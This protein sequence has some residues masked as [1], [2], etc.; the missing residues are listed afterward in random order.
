M[1]ARA[2]HGFVNGG[3]TPVVL[4]NVCYRILARQ[5]R[6]FTHYYFYLSRRNVG[7]DGWCVGPLLSLPD[8]LLPER[9][10]LHRKRTA[11]RVRQLPQKRPTL[12]WPLP[13]PKL[14]RPPPNRF[15]A[16]VIRPRLDYWTLLLGPKFSRRER[17]AMKLRRFYAI[18]EIEYCC[19]FVFQRHF[20]IHRIFERGC[21]IGLCRLPRFYR[22]VSCSG[23][24]GEA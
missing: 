24:C 16:E 20:L 13:T 2:T 10:Q 6:R 18:S 12:F 4:G 11:P 17:A 7:A 3:Y 19:N 8:H 21:E 22:F 14:C 9:S 1:D 5:R 15:R 23:G